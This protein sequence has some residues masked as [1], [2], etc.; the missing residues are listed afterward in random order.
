MWRLLLGTMGVKN[1][2]QGLNAAA[3]AGF[4]PRTVWSEVRCRNRL[5]T[6]PLK[7]LEGVTFCGGLEELPRKILNSRWRIPQNLMIS[8]NCQRNFGCPNI[9]CSWRK[10]QTSCK[11]VFPEMVFNA[12]W[13]TDHLKYM[14][15]TCGGAV[16]LNDLE[17]FGLFEADEKSVSRQMPRSQMSGK[18]QDLK[19][20]LEPTAP[21]ASR[22]EDC[23]YRLSQILNY[24]TDGSLVNFRSKPFQSTQKTTEDVGNGHSKECRSFDVDLHCNTFKI[25]FCHFWTVYTQACGGTGAIAPEHAAAI[26]F[27]FGPRKRGV[28][29]HPPNPPWLRAWWVQKGGNDE[30]EQSEHERA[31]CVQE[32]RSRVK[33]SHPTQ[34][35]HILDTAGGVQ[36]IKK[37]VCRDSNEREGALKEQPSSIHE[38][39]ETPHVQ[40]I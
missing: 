27:F 14:G 32:R 15:T 2:V 8:F 10:C 38:T 31:E 19:S 16:V 40:T 30:M 18:I 33:N 13:C 23:A 11:R 26:D 39:K 35:W 1:L 24:K 9:C 34:R 4:E 36:C 12:H 21:I 17:E 29:S 3:T 7:I 37:K 5:A 22:S 6:A 20:G 28:R 25:R